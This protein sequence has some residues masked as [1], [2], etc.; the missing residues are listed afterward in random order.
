MNFRLLLLLCLFMIAFV[1]TARPAR[2]ADAELHAAVDRSTVEVGDTVTYTLQ[3]TVSGDAA[4]SDAKPGP[5]P[6]FSR[7]SVSQAPMHMRSIVNGTISETTTLVT[8]WTLRATKTGTFTLGPPWASI[9]ARPHA[10]SGVR[11][12]VVPRG[13]GAPPPRPTPVDPFGGSP[14]D[15]WKGLLDFGDE[16]RERTPQQATA[17]PKLSLD[18]ERAPV[19]FLHAT[20]DKTHAVV[21]EQVTLTVY[22]YEDPYARQGQPSDVHEPTATNFVK[23]SLLEDETRAVGVGTANVGGRLW[24][25]KLVRKNALFPLKAGRLEIEPMSLTLPRARVGLRESERLSVDVSEPPIAGRPPG[26][27]VG[28]VGELSLSSTVSPRTITQDGAL[29]VT[30]EL[31]GTGNLPAQLPLPTVPG[32]EWLEP[33]VTEKLGAQG[34]DRFGGTK[35]FA[36]VVRVHKAGAVDLGEVR[37]PY[38]DPNRHAYAVAR[39]SLGIVDVAPG[40]A[41]H[42]AGAEQ[43]EAILAGLPAPRRAL[44]SPKPPATLADRPLAWAFLFG[45]PLACV[46]AVGAHGLVRRARDRRAAAAPSR[47]EIAK[48]RRAEAD[49]ACK[50][51]DGKAALG[52]VA[53]AIE[54][55]VLDATGVN[56]R[57]VAGDAL[58]REL[59]DAGVG[60]DDA[61]AI[62]EV[63]RACEDARFSPED[64]PASVARDAWDRAKKALAAVGRA[65]PGGPA[66]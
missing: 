39:A 51:D 52:A 37:L 23:R 24:S 4:I 6:G 29:G 47:D 15:P 1:A 41:G 5:T 28:D 22:L 59:E 62:V 25:V 20:I 40:G 8:S 30:I 13:H 64:V 9:N 46:L 56:A 18:V 55:S 50:G 11:V 3:V 54:A 31:R 14:F 45:S 44:E 53:R 42:D 61:R 36:Y 2:A 43:A 65:R 66:S 38:Y 57:G 34:G 12:T 10:A 21:G 33:Q 35:T 26:Y 58:A 60:K 63:L 27:A 7:E 49:R 48:K 19:A 32:V 16:P 17:D